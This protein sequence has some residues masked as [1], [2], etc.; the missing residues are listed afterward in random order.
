[1]LSIIHVILL[2]SLQYLLSQ[3][4]QTKLPIILGII[5]CRHVNLPILILSI[6]LVAHSLVLA[7]SFNISYLQ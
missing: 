4:L 1:M 6:V 7:I 5:V 2:K 3:I